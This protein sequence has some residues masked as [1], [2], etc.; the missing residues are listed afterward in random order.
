MNILTEE[1]AAGRVTPFVVYQR[2]LLSQQLFLQSVGSCMLCEERAAGRVT[3]FVVYQRV[4]LSKQLFLQ[5]VG[6]CMLCE[7]R[8]AGRVTPIDKQHC[9][10]QQLYTLSDCQC[11]IKASDRHRVSVTLKRVTDIH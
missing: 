2:V 4:L 7:E 11:N 9:L 6:S 1:R 3:P 5:S 8:A 10:H